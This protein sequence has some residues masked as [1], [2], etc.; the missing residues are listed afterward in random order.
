MLNNFIYFFI[1]LTYKLQF[2]FW[3]LMQHHVF[4]YIL[5]KFT[6]NVIHIFDIKLCL[7]WTGSLTI[8]IIKHPHSKLVNDKLFLSRI[9]G[10]QKGMILFRL[11]RNHLPLLFSCCN[12]Q[13]KRSFLNEKW[14]YRNY[15]WTFQNVSEIGTGIVNREWHWCTEFADITNCGVQEIE[16]LHL[17]DIECTFL[18]R[19]F[20]IRVK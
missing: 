7:R 11:F 19:T 12:I 1:F 2:S 6:H 4:R 5:R 15:F 16:L 18:N 8:T 14:E 9:V 13:A 20:A 3:A 10:C 17:F